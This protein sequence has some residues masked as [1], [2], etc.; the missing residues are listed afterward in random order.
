MPCNCQNNCYRKSALR[1]SGSTPQALTDTPSALSGAIAQIDTGCSM[2][3]MSSGARIAS[4]GLYSISASV[5]ATA[6]AAGTISAQLYL[7]GVPLPDTLRTVTAAI[8]QVVIPVETL[9]CLQSNCCCGHTVQL[10]VFGAATGTVTAW[11]MDAVRQ[12]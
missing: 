10:Y 7:D 6:T 5:Q 8:G 3:P 9:L 2:S 11:D 1:V 12:A 4:S